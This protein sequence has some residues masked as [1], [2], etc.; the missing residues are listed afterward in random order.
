MEKNT[1]LIDNNKDKALTILFSFY[2]VIGQC[3]E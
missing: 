3:N 2:I 1:A